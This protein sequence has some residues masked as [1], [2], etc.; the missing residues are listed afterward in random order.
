MLDLTGGYWVTG[1]GCVSGFTGLYGSVLGFTG[2][3][4]VLLVS[5]LI[6]TD[7]CLRSQLSVLDLT[8]LCIWFPGLCWVSIICVGI[9]RAELGLT[10][11]HVWSQWSM[12]GFDGLCLVP[13]VFI[14]SQVTVGPH[15]SMLSL[16]GIHVGAHWYPC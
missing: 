1:Y 14:E 9:H 4:V 11:L 2:L 8:G 12:L 6:F 7:L 15:W 3:F 10:Y 13:L 5:V 16:T